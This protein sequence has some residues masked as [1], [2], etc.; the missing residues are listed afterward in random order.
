MLCD[1]LAPAGAG[2][3]LFSTIAASVRPSVRRVELITKRCSARTDWARAFPVAVC[4][5]TA[6]REREREREREGEGGREMS[7]GAGLL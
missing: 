5:W 3:V 6:E 4:D 2:R 7:A 1:R